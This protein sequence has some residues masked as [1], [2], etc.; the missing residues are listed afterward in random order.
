MISK[1]CFALVLII[2]SSIVGVEG[3]TSHKYVNDASLDINDF[4]QTMVDQ[5]PIPF[6]KTFKEIK[7]HGP[8]SLLKWDDPVY[9]DLGPASIEDGISSAE[10]AATLAGSEGWKLITG[11]VDFLESMWDNNGGYNP[12][13]WQ[14]MKEVYK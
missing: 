2:F 10:L 8:S 9:D 7:E 13:T 3:Q 11:G 6:A 5:I 4:I 1:V 12:E 14:K